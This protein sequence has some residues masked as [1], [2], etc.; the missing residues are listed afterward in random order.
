MPPRDDRARLTLPSLRAYGGPGRSPVGTDSVRRK[1]A[2]PAELTRFVGRRRELAEL[3]RL[4]GDSPLVTL[5]GPGG[6]GKTRLAARACA[7][8]RRAF[9]DGIWFVELAH[10]R[11][12][13]LLAL[14][15][16]HGLDLRDQSR[17]WIVATLGEYL[18]SKRLLL[19]LDNCEH[20][21]AATAVFAA[22]LLQAAPRLRIIATSREPLGIHGESVLHVQPLS[23]PDEEAAL[24]VPAMLRY[25]AIAL[26]VDRARA[27]SPGFEFEEQGA[28]AAARLC[29]RLDGLPLAIE[30]AAVR[31][32]SFSV[33]EIADR[34]DERFGFLVTGNRAG[35]ARQQ[36]LRAAMDWS[37][38]MLSPDEKLLWQRLSVFRGGFDLAAA[39]AVCSGDGLSADA[40][41]DVVAALVEKSILLRVEA[42]PGS[43]YRLLET[44][45][46]YAREKLVDSGHQTE[47][48]HRH[49]EWL[50]ALAEEAR[51]EWIGP[52]QVSWFDRFQLE[53]GNL[54][55]A[56]E[57]CLEGPADAGRGLMIATDVWLY[58]QARGHLAEARRWLE[59]LLERE[60]REN[61][62]RVRGLWVAGY[63]AV[64][65]GDT[66]A[67]TS[68]LE[69]ALRLARHLRDRG[70]EG[71][72][73]QYLGLTAL[74]SGDLPEAA[75]QLRAGAGIHRELGE[76]AGAFALADL[77]IVAILLGDDSEAAASLE[78][79]VS[80]SMEQGDD[81]TRGHA[82]WGLGLRH[83]RRREPGVAIPLLT[84]SLRLMRRLDERTGI[85]L[86]VDVLAWVAASDHRLEDAAR[87]LG[88]ATAVWQSIPASPPPP[89]SEPHA[90]YGADVL[91]HLGRDAFDSAHRRGLA[92]SRGE[93]MAS[94]LG[95]QPATTS[96]ATRRRAASRLTRREQEVAEVVSHGLTNKEIAARLLI[97]ERT[98]ETHIEHI[99]DKLEFVS[100]AQIAAWVRSDDPVS[101]S[102]P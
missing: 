20:L 60:P 61:A 43:R 16:A 3:K 44:V 53:H 66:A 9:S 31:L 81:W 79:S 99:M 40:I 39:R 87:L 13:A 63:L 30:L 56:L 57:F 41:A 46:E 22:A 67:A 47:L 62:A 25:D 50:Q 75:R 29:R 4:L 54:R 14:T 8:L 55:S 90:A 96:V 91:K 2:G 28:A 80:M 34:L 95:E 10:V 76:P 73:L 72:A 70:A 65:Q 93:A 24:S 11:D 97:A 78:E 45:R 35:P 26:F 69:D 74:F 48:R 71:F 98:V 7:D 15:V 33:A 100:R 68:Y 38:E 27:A 59:S 64:S 102:E 92:M 19:V 101:P 21:L 85:A 58:W 36:T 83:W 42:V 89:V 12:P 17:R 18:A 37:Y 5:T 88:A 52:K 1:S 49:V 82:L 84:E 77:G 51:S 6:V 23:L 86:A 32:R 94:A